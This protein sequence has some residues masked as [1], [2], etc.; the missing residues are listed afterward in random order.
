MNLNACSPVEPGN[1]RE[2]LVC[3]LT[4]CLVFAVSLLISGWY[5]QGDQVNYHAAYEA[6][7]GLGWSDSRALYDSRISGA[8]G[9][10]YL[11]ML[12]GGALEIDKNLFMSVFNG[13]LA[14]YTVRLFRCW[15]AHLWL[16]VVMVLSNYYFYVLYFAAERLK[17]ASL[18]LVLSLVYARKPLWYTACAFASLWSHFSV[19]FIYSGIWLACLPDKIA[20]WRKEKA[21]C[22]G[23]LLSAG[24]VVLGFALESKYLLWKLNTYIAGSEPFSL[25]KLVPV[26]GLLTFACLY[27]ERRIM[28]LLHFLPILVGVAILGGSRLNM[29]AYFIFLYY[30]LR[31]RG[32]LNAGVLLS[33]IYFTYKTLLFVSDI[34]SYGHGFP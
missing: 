7:R 16:A 30:G 20:A 26:L 24:V 21:A 31:V 27:A 3:I 14:A 9:I 22:L 29:L 4:G 17:F 8:E 13:I 5:T 28:A 25:P 23:L 11:L 1:T 19:L 10:H 2:A 32:G 18:L 6:I 12:L 33:M 34:A 15:G